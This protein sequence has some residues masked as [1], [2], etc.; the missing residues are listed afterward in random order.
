MSEHFTLL[1]CQVDIP[2]TAQAADRD[3]HLARLS[4]LIDR[5]LQRRAADLVLLPELSSIDYSAQS[6]A[7]LDQLAESLD[8]PSFALWSQLAKRHHAAVAYSFAR[9]AAHGYYITLAICGRDGQLLGHYDKIYLAQFGASAEKNYFCAGSQVLLVDIGG[10]RLAPIICADIRTPE[11]CRTLVVDHAA[12][13]I[14]HAGAYYRDP[15]FYSWHNFAITR[16]LENQVYFVSLNR[17]GTHYGDSLFVPPWVDQHHQPTRFAQHDEQLQYLTL[18]KS[19][20][21]NAR[22]DYPFLQ[23]RRSHYPLAES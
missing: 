14:L 12:E 7:A 17:A 10:F 15:S 2:A 11:L 4:D 1:A 18:A 21:D 5:Q 3:A 13:V 19:A 9:R 16:A 22:R 6:F 23:D 8:G 20:I